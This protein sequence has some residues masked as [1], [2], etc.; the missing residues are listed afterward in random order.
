[1]KDEIG[2]ANRVP[3]PG[4]VTGLLRAWH[5][6]DPTAQE[7]LLP[8]VYGELRRLAKRHL[9]GERPG[10]TLQPS[11]VVN[12]TYLRL[13]K[14]PAGGWNDR[15]HFFAVASRAM[16]EI[17]VDYARRRAAQKRDG[18]VL[19][20]RIETKAM[21]L[22]RDVDIIAVDDALEK[23]ATLD[24]EQVKIV[25]LR[26]FGGLTVEEAAAALQISNATVYRKWALARAWLHRELAGAVR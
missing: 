8:L 21:T 15:V 17:L 7:R 26:F 3:E 4:E 16:R 23:L 14:Q 9:R 12:E 24:A 22:P 11:A 25:E 1:M 13:V 2:K 6:G 19:V 20:S 10:H 5:D 18:G